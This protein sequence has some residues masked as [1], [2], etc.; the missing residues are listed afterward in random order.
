MIWLKDGDNTL[1]QYVSDYMDY[2][3]IGMQP[4]QDSESWIA[5]FA[6][7]A[8]DKYIKPN[9]KLS[10]YIKSTCYLQIG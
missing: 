1:T 2:M 7:D 3:E 5:C 9:T 6:Q 4:P 8:F 10:D